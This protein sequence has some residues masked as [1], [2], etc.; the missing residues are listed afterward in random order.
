MASLLHTSDTARRL[1]LGLYA[2]WLASEVWI[3]F[4]RPAHTGGPRHDRDT[5][6]AIAL[7]IA[8][9]LSLGGRVSSG[10]SG[11]WIVYRSWLL[12]WFG[13]VVGLAGISLRVWAVRTLGR[14]FQ[15][16]LVVQERH[17]VVRS[18]PYRVL[19]HP[20]YAGPILTCIGLGIIHDNWLSL[21][22]FTALPTAAFAYRISVEER[23]LVSGLGEEYEEYRR[24]TWRLVPFVW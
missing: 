21:V 8:G 13:M 16:S 23:M 24:G 5:R 14:F 12:F 1:L 22:F 15:L 11:P 18:G 10:D 6:V 17:H 4:S 20:S 3:R 2:C 7:G 19:R 9:G